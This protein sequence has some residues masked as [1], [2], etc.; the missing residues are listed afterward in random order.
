MNYP[1][2]KHRC[3][4]KVNYVHLPTHLGRAALHTL[5][6]STQASDLTLA[7][8]TVARKAGKDQRVA[9]PELEAYPPAVRGYSRIPRTAPSC[10]L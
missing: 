5:P 3:L 9:D 2:N 4:R 10:T 1:F 6:A 8:Q 7:F